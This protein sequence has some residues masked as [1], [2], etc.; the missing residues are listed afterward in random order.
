MQALPLRLVPVP[1]APRVLLHLVLLPLVPVALLALLPLALQKLQRVPAALLVLLHPALRVPPLAPVAGQVLLLL[2]PLLVLRR[3]LSAVLQVPLPPVLRMPRPVAAPAVPQALLGLAPPAPQPVA[4][5][6]PLPPVQRV[7]PLALPVARQV[8]PRLALRTARLVPAVLQAPLPPARRVPSLAPPPVARLVLL[9]A[10]RTRQ[11]VPVAQRV[12]L[13]LALGA[14][15]PVLQPALLQTPHVRLLLRAPER[16]SSPPRLPALTQP[17]L[18][19]R[20]QR[21]PL[22]WHQLW[23]TGR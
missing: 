15:T 5:Q 11:R 4:L 22:R 3:L 2:V 16:A 13:L 10:L 19:V 20:V 9:L 1:A 14:S 12:L 17:F 23:T 7:P 6:A 18:R 8:R 21:L